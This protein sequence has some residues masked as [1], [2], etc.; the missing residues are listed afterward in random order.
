MNFRC[1]IA[2]R[3]KTVARTFPL[4][5]DNAN[6]RLSQE[7]VLRFRNFASMVT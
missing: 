7:R 1:M 4:S 6:D 3:N 5:F 2:L